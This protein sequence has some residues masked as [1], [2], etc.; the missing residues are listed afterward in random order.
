MKRLTLTGAE[1]L[2]DQQEKE[3]FDLIY[4]QHSPRV[5]Y[6]AFDRQLFGYSPLGC[7]LMDYVDIMNNNDRVFA[8]LQARAEVCSFYPRLPLS[9]YP[10][11]LE[12]NDYYIDLANI[13]R[14]FADILELNDK[15]Y[16]TD[17][18]AVDFGHGP[19]NMDIELVL[20]RLRKLLEQ[21][22]L[23]KQAYICA[24]SCSALY[25]SVR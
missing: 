7:Y 25:D 15:V 24:D 1:Q 3:L 12:R 16:K 5:H 19:A 9:L 2:T 20:S 18:L 13:D 22:A 23:L 4:N 8:D 17:T 21:S 10:V 11:R 14:H 6:L